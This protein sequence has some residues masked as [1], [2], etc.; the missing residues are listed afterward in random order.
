MQKKQKLALLLSVAT[1]I[2]TLSMPV[3]A[4]A[5][6][7]SVTTRPIAAAVKKEGSLVTY[8]MPDTWANYV[9][10]Y[11][12]Y[13]KLYGIT[14]KDTD[15][16]SAEE[17]A[18]FKAEKNN[19]IADLGDVGIAFGTVARAEKVV[20]P[21]KNKYW[22]EVP[23]WAK[24]KDGYWTGAYTGTIAFLVNKKLVKDVPG[25][26]KDLL[27]IEYKGQVVIGD[28]TKEAEAQNALLSAAFA[29]GGSESNITPGINYFKKLNA[30]GN[31]KSIKNSVANIQK[32]EVPITIVWDFNALN[33]RKLIGASNYAVVI[34]SDG[35][36]KSA[37]VSVINAYAR[38]PNAAKAFQDYLF[39]DAG[40]IQLAQGFA[41]PI[42]SN[43]KLPAS[44]KSQL[45]PESQ[46]KSA[47]NI[48]NY[49]AWE[50]TCKEIPDLWTQNVMA[51]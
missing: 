51:Q 10:I 40:Q 14:H 41:R 2:T 34:P 36:V 37:Y 27:K 47:R 50:K 29:N 49:T 16:S 46:Y 31:M 15:M 5:K 24:D 48:K 13:T 19:P 26:W 20:Q 39:S 38:H 25:S 28:V 6:K 42:R 1:I 11:K 7:Q 18:K 8:G 21:Y 12:S 32:D 23:S 17:L 43:V 9:S 45:L 44:V 22:N 35:A 4:A 3:Y 30:M 33:Y